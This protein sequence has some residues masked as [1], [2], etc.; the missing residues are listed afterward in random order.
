[1]RNRALSFAAIAAASVLSSG[2]ACAQIAVLPETSRAEAQ[3]SAI[4]NSLAA[5]GQSRAAAQQNQ[6]EVNSLRNESSIRSA[7][8]PIVAAPPIAGPAPVRR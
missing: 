2:A 7:P 5:Q 1:M 8:A 3:S 4:N 6:F